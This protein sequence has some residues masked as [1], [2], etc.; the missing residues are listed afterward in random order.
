MAGSPYARRVN[1]VLEKWQ[2]LYNRPTKA[3]QILEPY[4]A[5]LGIPYRFQHLVY[6]Y[7]T[8]Y[9]LPTVK[10]VVELDGLEHKRKDR[11]LKDAERTAWF[12]KHGW[13]VIRIDDTEVF[14]DPAGALNRAMERA[15]LPYR[16]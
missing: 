4:V 11:Q 15:N 10:T 6:H 16:V 13:Q 3:E 9:C 12:K 2:R 1:P 14:D 8:D 7:V 5:K